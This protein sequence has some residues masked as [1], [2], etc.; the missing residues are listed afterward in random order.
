MLQGLGAG[1]QIS[2]SG[3]NNH[4]GSTP[5][6]IRIRG[7]R[8]LSGG[9]D[10]LVVVDGIPF[11]GSLND[12]NPDDVVSS[13]ILKDA[14]ATAIYGSRG[15]NGVILINTRKGQEGEARVSYSGYVGFNKSLGKYD[16]YRDNGDGLLTLKKWAQINANPEGTFTGMDDPQSLFEGYDFY[17]RNR[18]YEAGVGTDWQDLIYSDGLLTNHQVSVSGGNQENPVCILYRLL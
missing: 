5:P 11:D 18:S 3:G 17:S 4:P 15:S 10:P 7:T 6:R 9:N 13:Q 1:V 2:K 16:V 8:S 14:S 12:I